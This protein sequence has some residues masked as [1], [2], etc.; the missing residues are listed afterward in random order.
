VLT[1]RILLIA[2]PLGYLAL[3]GYLLSKVMPLPIAIMPLA[4]SEDDERV[5]TPLAA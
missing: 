2:A 4:S 5:R 1:A 3:I